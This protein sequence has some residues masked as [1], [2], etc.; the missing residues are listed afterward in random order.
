MSHCRIGSP[1]FRP[2]VSVGCHA[3]PVV[4]SLTLLLRQ[5]NSRNAL[6]A[7]PRQIA[8]VELRQHHRYVCAHAGAVFYRADSL[9]V[10]VI[11]TKS[12]S[13]SQKGLDIVLLCAMTLITGSQ[14]NGAPFF[15]LYLVGYGFRV[16]NLI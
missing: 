2:D 4:P 9:R 3:V 13:E 5:L 14:P 6:L 1:S 16:R 10:L 11:Y 8:C 7:P 12:D 15:L